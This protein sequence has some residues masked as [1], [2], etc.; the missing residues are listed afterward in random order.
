MKK[1]NITITALAAVLVLSM[2]AVAMAGHGYGHGKRSGNGCAVYGM[3]NQLT[4]E[5]QAAVDTI[6]DKYQPKMTAMR[7]QI[8]AKHTTLQAMVNG[9][10]ADEQK[11]TA[12]TKDISSLRDQMRDTRDAMH[13]E[14]EKETGIVAFN[15]RGRGY[16]GDCYG[17][18][19]GAGHGYGGHGQ[20]GHGYHQ[21][22][23]N[24]VQ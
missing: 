20:G 5:K 1:R 21:G 9:G 15:E 10:N 4:P 24:Q 3:Y 2:A 18:G 13:A 6:V 16:A 17:Q 19:R 23:G 22:Q 11:I 8:R 7:D 12:L 14:L